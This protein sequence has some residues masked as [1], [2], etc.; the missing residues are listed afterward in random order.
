[1]V[2]RNNLKILFLYWSYFY[3]VR[4]I[5]QWYRWSNRCDT[6]AAVTA[7]HFNCPLSLTHCFISTS[8]THHWLIAQPASFIAF[9][10]TSYVILLNVTVTYV[11]DSTKSTKSLWI[12]YCNSTSGLR[13]ESTSSLSL[14]TSEYWQESS[15]LGSSWH[16]ELKISL[17]DVLCQFK[18]RNFGLGHLELW[19]SD[20]RNSTIIA[21]HYDKS[22]AK[23]YFIWIFIHTFYSYATR[24]YRSL[25]FTLTFRTI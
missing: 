21:T 25:T 14:E 23:L 5:S 11:T 16:N 19:C 12:N 20:I 1:M 7:S 24:A 10:I 13:S 22:G 3:S 8:L 9:I 17:E 2:H 18:E 4:L 6:N 15:R